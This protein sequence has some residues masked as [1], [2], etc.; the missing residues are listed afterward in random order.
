ML[1]D[2]SRELLI[3]DILKQANMYHF[4]HVYCFPLVNLV[5]R[6]QY[7]VVSLLNVTL[8]LFIMSDDGRFNC[9]LE[10]YGN[11]PPTRKKEIYSSPITVS[12]WH[13]IALR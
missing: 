2:A 8:L 10:G 11:I 12:R 9:G 5:I 13:D 4:V 6:L 1:I 7:S 3:R